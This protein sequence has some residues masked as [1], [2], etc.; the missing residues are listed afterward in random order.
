MRGVRLL[1][2]AGLAALLISLV[3]LIPA[4]VASR[5][6]GVPANAASGWSGTLWHGEA[7]HLNVA[8]FEAGPV[9]WQI[10]P[11]RL[12]TGQLAAGV[13]ATLPEGFLTGTV[14]LGLGG[15]V[16][17][18]SL[19]AAAPLTWLAPNLGANGG[20][21]AARFDKLA[22]KGGRI[23]AAIG[24]LTVAGVVLP[25]PTAGPKLGPGNYAVAFDAGSIGPEE[26]LMGVLSDAG[27]PLEITAAVKVTP[28]RSYE[29]DGT[30]KPRP[31]A[32]PELRDAL[33]MLGPATPDGGHALS[34]A[35]SF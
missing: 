3:S 16:A 10:R 33:R 8:G 26:P 14:A 34:L 23:T 31:D 18:S 9:R 12:L 1:A 30:A 2:A 27:G 6:L 13:E 15:G 28:P 19:E 25:V 32:P 21:V 17:I 29:V 20:Q 7:H 11:L 4:Q 24:T 22:W 5:W 35:G